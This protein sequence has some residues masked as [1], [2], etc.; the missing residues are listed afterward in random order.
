LDLSKFVHL[1]NYDR[2]FTYQGS[3]TTAPA[4]EGI[5]WNV[6]EQVIP[7]RQKTCDEFVK[8]RK[9]QEEI[10]TA[11]LVADKE[12]VDRW[13]VAKTTHHD[14]VKCQHIGGHQFMRIAV[15]NRKVQD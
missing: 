10:S 3:L 9:I 13:A 8:F 4:A 2:R 14:S 12:E 1:I 7:I 5:M 15:C 6:V 11:E